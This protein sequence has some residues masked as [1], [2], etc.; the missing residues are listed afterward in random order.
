[1]V[2]KAID[3]EAKTSLERSI[4]G[5]QKVTGCHSRK[6]RY[7]KP[8]RSIEIRTKIRLSPTISFFL[9]VSLKLRR[10]RM[11]SVIKI[12]EEAIQ[13]LGSILLR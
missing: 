11:T 3:I 5:T 1:M 9:I 4:L 2:K 10:L 13:P 8:I 7:T 6:I 12:V